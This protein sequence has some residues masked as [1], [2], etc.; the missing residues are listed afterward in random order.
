M[1]TMAP[2]PETIQRFFEF[3]VVGLLGSGYL[4]VAGSGYLDT[5]TLIATGLA[6]VVRL[7]MTAG[8]VRFR[9]P[10]RAVTA[11]T[12][13]YIG[14][15]PL[16]YQLISADFLTA[17]V[18][19][20][21]FLA[22]V[23]VLTAKTSRDF[24]FVKV[25]AF[26]ELL[27]ASVVSTGLSYFIFLAAFLLFGIAT[28]SSSEILHSMERPRT[29]SRNGLKF[30]PRRLAALSAC[31]AAGV[32]VL[33]TAMF[34]L[35]P[36]T[37]RAAFQHFA[38]S[39][40]HLAGFANGIELGQIGE[41]KQTGTPVMHV[42]VAD[43]EGQLHLKWRGATLA[44]FDG[45]R[46]FNAPAQSE[47][48]RGENGVIPLV[49][50][51][52]RPI[53]N[54]ISYDVQLR[55]AAL[56]TLFFAGV[57]EFV[58]APGGGI[59]RGVGGSYR[60]SLGTTGTVRYGAVS[61]L[62]E[63]VRASSLPEQLEAAL[64]KEYTSLPK[65][66]PRV[67][68]LA[69]QLTEGLTS[70]ADRARA[71][72]RHLRRSYSYTTELLEKEEADPLGHF[73]FTRKKGHCEYF[74]SA[75][76][77][78]TR[79]LQMPSRVATGFQSGVYNPVSGWHLIR[80]SDA[81]SWVEVWLPDRGWTTYD[82]TPPG[83][84]PRTGSLWARLM[85]YADAAETFWQEWV[86]S[87]DLD[88]QLALASHVEQSSR[89]FRFSG[90]NRPLLEIQELA[91]D[92]TRRFGRLVVFAMVA[93]AAGW[94]AGPRVWKW[95]QALRRVRRVQRGEVHASDATMLYERMLRV[96]AKRGFSKP[97][98]LTPLEFARVLPSPG[99]ALLVEDLTSAYN[100]LRFGGNPEAAARFIRLLDR[101]ERTPAAGF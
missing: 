32:L 36:R 79:A 13:A 68:Q 24:F 90:L 61:L 42:R 39:R 31:V 44:R 41:L 5:P 25:V 98:W 8:V 58:Q 84:D 70:E 23:K 50:P 71:I 43:A 35:L 59:I 30:F 99:V 7:L 65:L 20:V 92:L 87:Y 73:L 54:R 3:S 49:D 9:L 89:R 75:M 91:L 57:P 60:L 14:F 4:A 46:W 83:P 101:L 2:R 48:A 19:L 81:H 12:L 11:I 52:R 66:D 15:Y 86:L 10:D 26:L 85:F 93:L 62:P 78:M 29:V 22:I 45:R 55:T 6:I 77:V 28:F 16:D 37:A 47:I 80:A 76:A 18:H 69:R 97:A 74:A 56:D 100:D 17:T 72:E 40:Y 64:R 21:F 33:A 53:G 96:L 1:K 51:L 38:G 82:P 34:F 27:A 63:T 94:F 95:W 67:A 88:R